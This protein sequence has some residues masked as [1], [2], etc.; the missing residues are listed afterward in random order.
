MNVQMQSK[1][2]LHPLQILEDAILYSLDANSEFEPME[3][4]EINGLI[5]RNNGCYFFDG[6]VYRNTYE[7]DDNFKLI[8]IK[9]AKGNDVNVY[10]DY[11]ILKGVKTF[12]VFMDNIYELCYREEPK[13]E[14]Q[15]IARENMG[16]SVL[17]DALVK[18]A[19]AYNLVTQDTS[20][21]CGSLLSATALAGTMRRLPY[22]FAASI[23]DSL[24]GLKPVDVESCNISFEDLKDYIQERNKNLAYLGIFKQ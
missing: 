16:N 24:F 3:N 6:V 1:D 11:Y 21:Y 9:L 22:I 18:I 19:E 8:L 13:N 14:I 12:V 17:F 4:G 15:R 10:F 20:I 5:L 7:I 23:V 2:V